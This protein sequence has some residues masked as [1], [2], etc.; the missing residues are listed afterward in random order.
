ME[1]VETRYTSI[2][3]R[4]YPTPEQAATIEATI[5]G[6]RYL[7]NQML[8]DE[9]EFFAA[10]DKH[11]IPAPAKYKRSAPFLAEADSQ[12]LNAVHQNL[13]KTFKEF[14]ADPRYSRYPCFKK[15]K[16][17]QRSYRTCCHHRPGKPDSVRI[18]GDGIV[19]PRLRWV[20]AKMHRRPQHWWT[21]QH[22]TVS[23][24]P[25][26]KYFCSLTYQYAVRPPEPVRPDPAK[27]LGLQ[28][29]LEHFC[30]T[31]KGET[32]D[33]PKWAAKNAEKI[34]R[35]QKQLGRMVRGSANYEKQRLKLA[36][37]Y[38]R[39]ANQRRDYIHKLSRRIANASDGVCVRSEDLRGL[40]GAEGGYGM[41]RLCLEYKL[42]RL[43]KPLVYI[44]G[45]VRGADLE[46]LFAG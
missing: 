5:D 43:G 9:R 42:K 20:K 28:Y 13:Q 24:T 2:K 4:I 31:D 23:K 36:L 11:Y 12:A 34:N 14:F 1:Q 19:L 35:L 15:K 21:L 45:D 22:A 26:G 40:K 33:P 30:V 32:A 46:E 25:A 8:S 18:E 27:L 44:D 16:S 41:L 6:C 7:W 10:T 29:S 17:Q 38:E 37:V 3:L 39:I